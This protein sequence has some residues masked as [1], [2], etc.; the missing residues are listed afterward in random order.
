MEVESFFSGILQKILVRENDVAPVGSVIAIVAMGAE[1]GIP[2]GSQTEAT[3]KP[4]VA[5]PPP[6]TDKEP[7]Q[8]R[9][10]VTVGRGKGLK[11]VAKQG[12][13]ALASPAARR[14]AEEK[15][16]P[17]EGVEGTGPDGMVTVGDV[18]AYLEKVGGALPGAEPQDKAPQKE[19]VTR[20]TA[21]EEEV[22]E[23]STMRKAIATKVTYSKQN[24]PHFY[25]TFEVDMSHALKTLDSLND[26]TPKEERITLND[27]I[28]KGVA[29][30]LKQYPAL[31]AVYPEEGF[32]MKREV[33]VGVIVGLDEGLLIP[34]I[35]NCDRLS[36]P[37]ISKE[38]K[39][40]RGKVDGGKL[41]SG[42]L[43]GGTF[44]ISNLGP[45]GAEDFSAIIYPPQT[46]ILA[47][48]SVHEKPVVRDG[49]IVVSTRMKM[50]LSVDHRV[51]DGIMAANFL[52][53]LKGWLETF[54]PEGL[55]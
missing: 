5:E 17:L 41:T 39:G 6:E 2:I 32:V 50:T 54:R 34:V 42:D 28:I 18:T 35:K 43:S 29:G 10:L 8:A 9:K 16:I 47:V 55:T 37:Q 52:R 7:P 31:N 4:R 48:S 19:T 46:A 1:A 3:E 40:M 27:L 38:V 14:I 11:V 36:L 44:S 13:K 24:I 26:S 49:E 53:D 45:L 30:L 25:V 12:A 51:A 20:E 33:N 23:L 22:T 15:G 21:G